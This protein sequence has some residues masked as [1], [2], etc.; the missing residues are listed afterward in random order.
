MNGNMLLSPDSLHCLKRKQLTNLCRRFGIKAV[1]KN[2]D[3]IE[4]LQ[5]YA[6]SKIPSD[7]PTKGNVPVLRHVKRPRQSDLSED[8]GSEE[9]QTEQRPYLMYPPLTPRTRQKRISDLVQA[10]EEVKDQPDDVDVDTDIDTDADDEEGELASSKNNTIAFP[11]SSPTLARPLLPPLSPSGRAPLLPLSPPRVSEEPEA[12]QPLRIVKA[13]PSSARIASPLSTATIFEMSLS[14]PT[15][16]VNPSSSLYPDLSTLALPEGVSNDCLASSSTLPSITSR[17]FSAAAASVLAE[18]NARLSAAGRFATSGSLATMSS[19]GTWQNLTASASSQGMS[20]SRSGRY[21][22]HHERQ[23]NKMD[24]IVNHYAAKRVGGAP[25]DKG[26]ASKASDATSSSA[27]IGNVATT[28]IASTCTNRPRRVDA[29]TST[30]S[31]A[32]MTKSTSTCGPLSTRRRPL[33]VPPV[34]QAKL[35]SSL[36]ATITT[37]PVACRQTSNTSTDPPRN[38]R[39]RL[40]VTDSLQNTVLDIPQDKKTIVVRI[41]RPEREGMSYK[42]Q[43]TDSKA[44]STSE[45]GPKRAASSLRKT[46]IKATKSTF[47]GSGG[48]T[49][50]KKTA[51]TS[52]QKK[53]EAAFAKQ[54]E[55]QAAMSRSISSRANLAAHD[56]DGVAPSMSVRNKFTGVVTTGTSMIRPIDKGTGISV[57]SKTETCLN[58]MRKPSVAPSTSTETSKQSTVSSRFGGSIRSSVSQ[59]LGRAEAARQ[60][61]LKEIKAKT[62]AA[63]AGFGSQRNVSSSTATITSINTPGISN[64]APELPRKAGTAAVGATAQVSFSPS[65]I[66]PTIASLSRAT[67]NSNVCGTGSASLPMLSAI[68]QPLLTGTTKGFEAVKVGGL[69]RAATIHAGVGKVLTP[70]LTPRSSSLRHLR[71]VMRK[72]QKEAEVEQGRVVA[73]ENIAPG[74]VVPSVVHKA[75]HEM[76]EKPSIRTVAKSE[77]VSGCDKCTTMPADMRIKIKMGIKPAGPRSALMAS[78]ATVSALNR[79]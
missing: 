71:R 72:Q 55:K 4:R 66:R 74:D 12:I 7:S 69:Q 73:A 64:V 67:A 13:L 32:A 77:S 15:G 30:R 58:G 60:A 24:S 41:T 17:Q 61:R 9:Q 68:T 78:R 6:A 47:V 16:G 27:T 49:S 75:A 26:M 25:M 31:L 45:N 44:G 56:D 18:M 52:E 46:V 42:F 79:F 21:E 5:D 70:S 50:A 10:I 35:P 40:A 63:L 28:L 23:F 43:V 19:M 76:E 33:P 36:T 14:P 62:K 54:Q 20:K 3:L 22:I 37:R 1:G 38:K 34:S 65:V 8:S 39:L 51:A 59:G 53:R 11:I 57:G 2:T 29:S 48:A